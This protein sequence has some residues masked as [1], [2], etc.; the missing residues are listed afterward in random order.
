[1]VAIF[2]TTTCKVTSYNPLAFRNFELIIN[3]AKHDL[4][5]QHDVVSCPSN[6][7]I[8][9]FVCDRRFYHSGIYN[10]EI[11]KKYPEKSLVLDF[12]DRTIPRIPGLYATI[13]AYL[14]QYP[15][16]EYLFYPHNYGCFDMENAMVAFSDYKYL[17]SFMG[18]VNTHPTVR[19]NIVNLSHHRAYLKDT[20]KEASVELFSDVLMS[21]KFVL[22]PRGIAASTIRVYE[23][24]R[25]GRVPVI[26]SNEWR[27][28]IIDEDWKEFSIVVP[29][30]DV[31]LIPTILEVAES[32]AIEMGE[33][34][35]SAW[36]RN[37]SMSYGFHWIVEACLR[38]HKSRNDYKR[39]SSRKIYTET[40]GTS[41]FAP[42]WK[43]FI[44][45]KIG[46]I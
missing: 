34:A 16:Y 42:F 23:A 22:C 5:K 27:E 9:L 20:S 15:I 12:A 14:Q 37:F 1:M 41:H 39:I 29:E 7:D 10:S 28:N 13:P 38:I 43:E 3:L 46:Q 8:I 21:S 35:R 19:G 6:A 11:F 2:L 25:A 24:M 32:K 26:I 33:K 31:A 40:F 18:N 45:G 4:Q 17:F 30:K 36:E 44:R